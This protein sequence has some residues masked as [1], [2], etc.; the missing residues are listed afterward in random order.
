MA[1]S[2]RGSRAKGGQGEREFARELVRLFAEHGLVAEAARTAQL[3]AGGRRDLLPRDVSTADVTC[4]LLPDDHAEVKRDEAG[5]RA[6]REALPSWCEQA[7]RDANGKRWF[8]AWRQNRQPW[9]VTLPLGFLT[10]RLDGTP[11]ITLSLADFVAMRVAQQPRVDV[12]PSTCACPSPSGETFVGWL[13]GFEVVRCNDCGLV[14]R[15]A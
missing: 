4:D 3:Q 9:R 14:E 5:G 2:G 15:A 11:L 13:Q 6:L 8:V 1:S 12:G 10:T 7:A